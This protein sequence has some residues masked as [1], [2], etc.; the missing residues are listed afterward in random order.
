M[1]LSRIMGREGGGWMSGIFYKE[2]IQTILLFGLETWVVS[3]HIGS[4]L[5]WLLPQGGL[6]NAR[7]ET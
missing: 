5:E 2:V 3:P 4:K 1:Q 7:E 6:S